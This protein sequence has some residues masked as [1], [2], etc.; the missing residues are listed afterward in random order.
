MAGTSRRVLLVFQPPDG[1]I[2]QHVLQL[3]LGLRDRDFG[4]EVAGP[5]DAA[6]R[7]T[8]KAAGLRF[9]DLPIKGDMLAPREDRATLGALTAAIADFGADIVHTH[10]QKA[11]LLGR[12]AARRAGVPSLYTP[13]SLVY[14]TQLLRPRRGARARM[15]LGRGVE[16]WLG[17]ST[18]ALIA[19]ASEE[20][21]AMV[22]DGLASA[23]R[24]HVVHNGASADASAAPDPRLVEFAA[25]EP[26]A[27]F[28]AGLRDQKGLP[29]LLA[30]LELL[31][32]RGEAV[33][34]AIVGN[35]ELRDMVAERLATGP[36]GPMT[37]LLPFDAP[38]EPYLAALDLF[39]LPSYWEGLPLAVLEAMHM[40]LPVV[41]TA[42]NGTPDAVSDGQTGLLV[43]PGDPPA[44][45]GA[46][47][48]LMSD[49]G[50]RQA[51]GE[52]A[53]R[54]AAERFTID[55]MVDETAVVY[56]EVLRH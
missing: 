30:A 41:A 12:M 29:D 13:N 16:R 33:R 46:I 14:R 7:S 50:R 27:G 5:A 8:V 26:L 1:G 48:E 37:L 25:G 36:A 39:V 31:A 20:R 11:G 45:A 43:A 24:V 35:G 49:A 44:L 17:R 23:D 40:G 55:R 19:V 10:G 34:F 56:A 32:Q 15:I 53:A 21:D 2:P 28:V 38:V 51:M 54:A 3:A 22:S 18:A 6:I 4:V 47:A 9:V 52:A 42:V